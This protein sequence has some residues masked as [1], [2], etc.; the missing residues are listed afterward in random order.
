MA[1]IRPH[2][3]SDQSRLTH[4]HAPRHASGPTYA[5]RC[6]QIKQPATGYVY[7]YVTKFTQ[8]AARPPAHSRLF[9]Q[10]KPF[11]YSRLLWCAHCRVC[12]WRGLLNYCF[13]CARLVKGDQAMLD[14]YVASDGTYGGA[15]SPAPLNWPGADNLFCA[16]EHGIGDDV[17][18][19]RMRM[20][21]I[22]CTL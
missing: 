1:H 5:R 16:S 20:P 7:P 11:F 4:A 15:G 8:C 14:G 22:C 19:R 9:Y 2:C 18:T 17:R 13:I 6:V 10:I 3:P 12:T 21:R